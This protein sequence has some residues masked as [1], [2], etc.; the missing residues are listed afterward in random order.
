MILEAV[1]VMFRGTAELTD[2][3]EPVVMRLRRSPGVRI[4]SISGQAIADGKVAG[5]GSFD[6]GPD[7]G[8]SLVSHA[9]GSGPCPA[10][11]VSGRYLSFRNERGPRCGV[12]II[13]KG[14]GRTG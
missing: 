4:A 5:C 2:R 10:L 7:H 13:T 6:R 12:N 3:Y 14:A 11:M 8:D 1:P 9:D